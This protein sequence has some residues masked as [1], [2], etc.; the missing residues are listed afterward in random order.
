LAVIVANAGLRTRW[1][2][3]RTLARFFSGA[4]IVAFWSAM[5]KS[6]WF[7][8]SDR[9]LVLCYHAIANQKNDPVLAPYG[10]PL[11]R[12]TQQID[13]LLERG[14]VFIGPGLLLDF[15]AGKAPLPRRPVLLTFDD[16]YPE[17]LDLARDL[18][19]PRGIEALVFVVTGTA[20]GTNEWDQVHG[21]QKLQLLSL[22][23]MKELQ[24]H[25]VEIGSHSRTHRLMTQLSEAELDDEASG[26]VADL[27]A[28]GL[29]SPRFFAY[30][31]GARNA[32]AISAA[33]KAGFLAAF[34]PE[35]DKLERGS[36]PF[37]LPRVLILAEDSGWRF[38][39]KIMSPPLRTFVARVQNG[40]ERR[41][42]KVAGRSHARA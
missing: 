12:F 14:H 35:Q 37:D 39:L 23:Q 38:R 2:S 24:S 22:D 31:Y 7:P 16:G 13:W 26:S 10:V 30:P 29:P 41:L 11:D 20:S 40:L 21:A 9:L 15:L 18:F 27:I 1:R 34:G 5:K 17:L 6:G 28:D 3:S 36:D 8:P 19:A 33:R 32:A 25:G 42:K 4:R